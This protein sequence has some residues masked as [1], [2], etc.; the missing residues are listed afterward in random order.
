LYS[1]FA[2]LQTLADGLQ[3]TDQD[4][5]GSD[6]TRLGPLDTTYPESLDMAEEQFLAMLRFEGRG[7]PEELRGSPVRDRNGC[8]FPFDEVAE[9]VIEQNILLHYLTICGKL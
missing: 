1:P 6:Q 4:K 9:V 5:C 2:Y 3:K 8:A 7:K